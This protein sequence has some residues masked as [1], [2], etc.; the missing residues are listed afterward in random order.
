MFVSECCGQKVTSVQYH[1]IV[2]EVCQA[3]GLL[4]RGHNF[5]VIDKMY[6]LIFGIKK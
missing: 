6:D 1:C 3:H 4:Q 5:D 2:C